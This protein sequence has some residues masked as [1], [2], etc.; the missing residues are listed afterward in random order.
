MLS[1]AAPLSK[2]QQRHSKT[3]GQFHQFIQFINS[4]IHQF[5]N[6]RGDDPLPYR[7]RLVVDDELPGPSRDPAPL[8]RGPAAALRGKLL[9]CVTLYGCA[10]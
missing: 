7:R 5:I 1:V 9:P 4:S 6:P 10:E 2:V 8:E 3:A